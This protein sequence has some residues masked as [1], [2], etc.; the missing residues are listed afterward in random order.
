MG[1]RS[2]IIRLMDSHRAALASALHHIGRFGILLR[3]SAAIAFTMR[4]KVI[5]R[6]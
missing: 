4:C 6:R 3:V 2:I 1:N 5:D